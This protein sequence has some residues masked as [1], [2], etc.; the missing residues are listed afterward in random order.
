MATEFKISYGAP[1]GILP[2][3]MQVDMVKILT[4]HLVAIPRLLKAL[5]SYRLDDITKRQIDNEETKRQN[6]RPN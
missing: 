5:K 3:T 2:I 4:V 1:Q 6:E